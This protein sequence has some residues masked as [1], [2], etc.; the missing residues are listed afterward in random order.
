[1]RKNLHIAF[2]ITQVSDD[3][4]GYYTSPDFVADQVL[5]GPFELKLDRV[6][7]G[8]GFHDFSVSV[9]GYYDITADKAQKLL[10]SAA[11]KALAEVGS[12]DVPSDIFFCGFNRKAGHGWSAD[13]YIYEA[14]YET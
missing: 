1:M 13:G 3:V 14:G 4:K 10:Y 9:Y 6:S 5:V 7:L 12:D 11:E 2:D 8:A